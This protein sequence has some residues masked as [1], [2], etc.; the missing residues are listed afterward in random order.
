VT[1]SLLDPTRPERDEIEVLLERIRA[2][3]QLAIAR[4]QQ[5]RA[6]AIAEGRA[7]ERAELEG[8]HYLAKMHRESARRWADQE[9]RLRT[10]RERDLPRVQRD[11][12]AKWGR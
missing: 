7:A 8:H 4:E 9:E 10:A 11:L 6:W 1:I 2:Y 12:S 5:C 3:E